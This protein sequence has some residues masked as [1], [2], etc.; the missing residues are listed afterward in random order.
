MEISSSPALLEGFMPGPDVRE[1][2]SVTV[3][4]PASIVLDTACQFDLQRLWPA[5]L[6]FRMRE[7]VMRARVSGRRSPQGILAETL[8][9]GWGLL[10]R[11]ERLVIVGARCQ[12]WRGDVVFTAIPADEFAAYSAPEQVKIVWTLEADAL[13]PARTR[14]SHE[15]RVV[16]T[17]ATAR[18]RFRGYRRW[19]RFGILAIR[20]LML[21]A[22]RREAEAR[23]RG[24]EEPTRT[25][26]V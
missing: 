19:A 13:G 20:Y 26:S 21:P 6:I 24:S 9:L 10:Y 14:F 12:P 22:V 1:R 3:R 18:R 7:I 15:T 25:G 23:W 2:F 4:A 11:D 16:A 17:D 8:G 5:R